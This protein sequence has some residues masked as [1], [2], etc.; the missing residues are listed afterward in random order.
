[1]AETFGKTEKARIKS[2][3]WEY[4]KRREKLMDHHKNM[5][6][7]IK[8]WKTR[9]KIIEM[10]QEKVIAIGNVVATFTGYNIKNSQDSDLEG[11][12]KA[13]YLFY[14]YGM[15]DGISGK[16]LREYVGSEDN[17]EP[18]KYRM[19]FTR[20]FQKHPENSELYHRFKAYI[21]DLITTKPGE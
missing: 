8:L 1:M 9:V 11:V 21:N 12:K 18:S 16:L 3:I 20:S 17:T 14:K 19:K 4:E 15:E 7:K 6:R 2:W 5:S 10:S 13:K